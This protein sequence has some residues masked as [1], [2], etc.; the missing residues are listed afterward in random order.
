MVILVS[1]KIKK[2]STITRSSTESEYRALSSLSFELIWILK[3]L[4]DIGFK[5]SIPVNIFYD[6]ESANK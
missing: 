6:N 1:W 2:Q 5:I 3:I 4:Y